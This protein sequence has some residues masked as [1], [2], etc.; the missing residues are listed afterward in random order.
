[1][2]VEIKFQNPGGYMLRKIFYIIIL[3]GLFYVSN[4]AKPLVRHHSYELFY[5]SLKPYGEWIEIDNGFVV[6]RPLKIHNGWKPYLIGRWCWTR[7]G[8]YWDSFEPFGWA[9]Y[10]YGRW[11][12]DD[13]YGWIWIPDDEWGPAWVEWRH[14]DFYIGWA[15]LP[16]YAYFRIDI[17]IHFTINWHSHYSYWNFVRYEHFCNRN[18]NYYVVD[19][20]RI[21][22]IFERTK[23][24][25][26]YYY[27]DGRIINAGI[28]KSIV[29]RKARLRIREYEVNN[30][31]DY[32]EFGKIKDR[33]KNRIY[34]YRL[35]ERDYQISSNRNFELRIAERKST[36]ERDKLN[37]PEREVIRRNES[38]NKFESRNL[39]E[40]NTRIEKRYPNEGRTFNRERGRT[41][42]QSRTYERQNQFEK[43]RDRNFPELRNRENENSKPER[44]MND[45]RRER[46]FNSRIR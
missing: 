7:Y 40:S 27:R 36:L 2:V 21:Q 39:E 35:G 1:M 44:K 12:Y 46:D 10:H 43:Q 9:V 15:P 3:I 4:N 37:L 23:Y 34:T 16:P 28:D 32:K 5:F 22:D 14:D 33:D 41:P 45:V 20:R 38:E 25:N 13:Y 30:I 19:S 17:G 8:W 26:D 42:E 18:V 24:R 6:W 31:D 29:E 11:Y